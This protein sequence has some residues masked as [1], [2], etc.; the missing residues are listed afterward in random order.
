M[1]DFAFSTT[2]AGEKCVVVESD[3]F[4][5][6]HDLGYSKSIEMDELFMEYSEWLEEEAE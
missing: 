6:L 4:S 5:Y 3:F 2:V 1:M